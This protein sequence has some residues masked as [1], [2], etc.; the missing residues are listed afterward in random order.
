[1]ILRKICCCRPPIDLYSTWKKLED[2]LEETKNL[3]WAEMFLA[4]DMKISEST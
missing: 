4:D 3:F 1:M 2:V